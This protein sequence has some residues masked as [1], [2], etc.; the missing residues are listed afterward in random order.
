MDRVTTSNVEV[1]VET[2]YHDQASNPG[3]GNYVYAYQITITNYRSGLVQLL[4]REWRI[5]DSIGPTKIVKGLGVVGEQPIL[6]SGAYHRYVSGCN[7]KTEMG[8][9][10]GFY[11]FKN[12]EDGSRFKVQ[13]PKFVLTSPFALN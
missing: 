4:S 11:T 13:I 5:K 6:H 7:F 3:M 12:L 1:S 10:Q 2:W 9:M 8:S